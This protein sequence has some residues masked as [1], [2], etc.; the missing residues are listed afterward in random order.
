M[1]LGVPPA[2]RL[3]DGLWSFLWNASAIWMHLDRGRVER[4]R[5]DLDTHD[6]LGLQFDA[7]G[8]GLGNRIRNSH[9][10]RPAADR[11]CLI[12]ARFAGEP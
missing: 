8:A 11:S 6:L 3:A 2:A 12:S 5:F 1:N 9:N 10:H 4:E 7:N